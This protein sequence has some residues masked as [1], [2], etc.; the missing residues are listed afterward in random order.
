MGTPYKREAPERGIFHI[1]DPAYGGLIRLRVRG[2]VVALL[3]G[4]PA[5][6][7]PWGWPRPAPIPA[8][9]MRFRPAYRR[10][11]I[12]CDPGWF[13]SAL[14]LC[15]RLDLLLRLHSQ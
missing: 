13:H 6:I 9:P 11:L 10:A 12:E 14:R 1:Y 4:A 7:R 2:P 15:D 3:D 5:P 8:L